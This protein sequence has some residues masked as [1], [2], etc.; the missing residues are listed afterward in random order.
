MSHIL[1]II[2]Y[3]NTTFSPFTPSSPFPLTFPSSPGLD[4]KSDEWQSVHCSVDISVW[5]TKVLDWQK[6]S[7]GKDFALATES[8]SIGVAKMF[9]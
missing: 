9:S 8:I 7:V 6:N 1:D 5:V 2:T 4:G 3:I